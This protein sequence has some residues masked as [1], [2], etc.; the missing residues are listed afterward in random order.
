[1]KWVRVALE[2]EDLSACSVLEV[3]D[4]RGQILRGQMTELD[5]IQ[6]RELLNCGHQCEKQ[7][8]NN[9]DISSQL[10][11]FLLDHLM[12][13]REFL[14]PLRIQDVVLQVCAHDSVIG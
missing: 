11:H 3:V 12:Q 10:D 7:K 9:S 5:L 1:M 14:L 13:T 2:Q 8:N 6:T 4:L